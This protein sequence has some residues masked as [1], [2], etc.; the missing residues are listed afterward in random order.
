M[1]KPETLEEKRA[2]LLIKYRKLKTKRVEKE[3]NKIVYYLSRGDKRYVMLCI[4]DEKTIGISYVRE[5]KELVDE[6][7][8]VKGI[9]VGSGKY[10]YS[11]M[12]RSEDLGVELIPPTLPTFDIFDHEMVPRHEILTEEERSEVL[13]KFHAQPYQFPWIKASDP[14]SIILGAE[15][16]DIIRITGKSTTAGRTESYRYVVK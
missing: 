10:T 6:E 16:G 4:L 5:L 3:A 7:K 12:S 8:A 14:M 9:M 15:A 1:S 11:A 2:A 13:E